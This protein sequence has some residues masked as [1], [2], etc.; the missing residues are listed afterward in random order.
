VDR[1]LSL[2]D[3]AAVG[4]SLSDLPLFADAGLAIAFNATDRARAL[5]DVEVDGPDLRAVLP[6][7]E[8]WLVCSDGDALDIGV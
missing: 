1:G 3:C 2:D 4:D 8:R 5:T 6:V 7:L